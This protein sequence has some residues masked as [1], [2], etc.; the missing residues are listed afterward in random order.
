M[1]PHRAIAHG[2]N[3]AVM[4]TGGFL[5]DLTVREGVEY[6]AALFPTARPVDEVVSSCA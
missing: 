5:R 2:L 6:I 3:S 1:D 4:Q